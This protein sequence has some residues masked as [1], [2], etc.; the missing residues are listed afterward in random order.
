[1]REGSLFAFGLGSVLCFGHWCSVQFSI[2]SFL[3]KTERSWTEIVCFWLCI[4]RVFCAWA[5]RFPSVILNSKAVT[6]Y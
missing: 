6:A 2:Y 4:N 1:M 3:G 5:K